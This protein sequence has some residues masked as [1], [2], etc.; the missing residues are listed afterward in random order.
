MEDAGA[1]W[2]TDQAA[3]PNRSGGTKS[4]LKTAENDAGNEVGVEEGNGPVTPTPKAKGRAKSSVKTPSSSTKR[5]RKAKG[6]DIDGHETTKE[7]PTLNKRAKVTSH[8]IT[9]EPDEVKAEVKTE[10]DGGNEAHEELE[11]LIKVNG[12]V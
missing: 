7:N 5:G 3:T 9:A 4:A 6:S 11:D 12:A 1:L 2:T 10:H 8:T